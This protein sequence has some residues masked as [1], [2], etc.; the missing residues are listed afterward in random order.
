MTMTKQEIINSLNRKNQQ[1]SYFKKTWPEHYESVLISAGASWAEK[2]Y[3]YL[4][5]IAPGTCKECGAPTKFNGIWKGYSEYCCAS[6]ANKHNSAKVKQTKLQRYGSTGYNN[7]NKSVNTCMERYGVPVASQSTTAREKLSKP[8]TEE[9]RKRMSEIYWMKTAKRANEIHEKRVATCSDKYGVPNIMHDDNIRVRLIERLKQK[10]GQDY[11]KSLLEKS[12]RSKHAQTIQKYPD[13]IGHADNGDW[14]C[15]CTAA[16]CDGCDERTYITPPGIHRDRLRYGYNPCTKL[17]PVG[18]TNKN[19]G[20]EQFV[21]DVL[22]AHSIKYITNDRGTIGKELDIYIP[23]LGIAIECNGVYWHSTEFKHPKYHYEKFKLCEAYGIRLLTIWEDQIVNKPD[24]VKS[25]ILNKIG[26]TETR[27]W[28]RKCEVVEVEP[29][30]AQQFLL[31]NHIQG[32]CQ[33]K[34]KLGLKYNDRLVALMCFN[35][36]SKLSGSKQTD[37]NEWELIRFCNLINTA[38]V[39]GAGKLLK[40]FIKNYHPTKITSFSS[41]DIS[42]GNLYKQLGFRKGR[43]NIGYWYIK[44]C[45]ELTRYHRSTFTKDNIIAR[46]LAPSPNKSEWT[47]VEVMKTLPFYRIY[48]SG[49]TH[50][51]L[52]SITTPG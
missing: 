16:N 48:D 47:E 2:L 25:L 19:T 7:R 46:G 40:Y 15:A 3:T 44:N 6:C 26:K 45:K 51:E 1:E 21:R 31:C 13:V 30:V 17:N 8:K 28:A 9:Q 29:A 35:K 52:I 37:V 32:R 20:P 50:W 11:I 43:T 39:G 5:N 10:Y 24:I 18:F 22:D 41:N 34:V 23:D 42:D 27:I 36:R 33:S 4:Y 49:T 14:I 12:I 38:V